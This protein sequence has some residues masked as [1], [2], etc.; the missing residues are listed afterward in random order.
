M[1]KEKTFKP[2]P[3]WPVWAFWFII[4]LI[5][6]ISNGNVH[7][8]SNWFVLCL[9]LSLMIY[10]YNVKKFG[11]KYWKKKKEDLK[12]ITNENPGKKVR[13]IAFIW[14]GAFVGT[15]ILIFIIA[16]IYFMFFVK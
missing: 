1:A 15:I 7:A 13:K 2:L 16:L 6:W 4:F 8:V 9:I 12:P 5:S 11:K 14:L 10:S 3:V